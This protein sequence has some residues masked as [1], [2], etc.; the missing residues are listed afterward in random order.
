MPGIRL[1]K[2][3]PFLPLYRR[4]PSC[5]DTA[6]TP[7]TNFSLSLF[8]F[9]EKVFSNCGHKMWLCIFFTYFLYISYNCLANNTLKSWISLYFPEIW[10]SSL[11]T[12]FQMFVCLLQLERLGRSVVNKQTKQANQRNK[13]ICISWW[14]LVLVYQI[15]QRRV[16]GKGRCGSCRVI[17]RP[18]PTEHIEWSLL[19]YC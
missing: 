5:C 8:F 1:L 11:L 13:Q 14:P 9:P 16:D 6:K 10:F 17:W 4:L 15:G 19:S 3:D 2:F 12:Q 18:K 7:W